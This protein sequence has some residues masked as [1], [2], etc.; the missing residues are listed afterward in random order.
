MARNGRAMRTQF[1]LCFLLCVGCS[2]AEP[3]KPGETPTP[4]CVTEELCRVER[5]LPSDGEECYAEP[6]EGIIFEAPFAAHELE[7]ARCVIEALRDRKAGS[8]VY[9]YSCGWVSRDVRLYIAGENAFAVEYW[10]EGYDENDST[11]WGGALQPR[12]FYADCLS[13]P[14]DELHECFTELMVVSD[15]CPPY[16]PCEPTF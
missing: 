10:E 11:D 5:S 3:A 1:C 2:D 8:V 7:D 14:D 12:S 13:R 4:P 9:G 6:E 16:C 15:R